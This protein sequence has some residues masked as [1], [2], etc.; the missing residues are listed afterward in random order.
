MNI[1]PMQIK[2]LKSSAKIMRHSA[3]DYQTQLVSTLR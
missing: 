2:G 3:P 1:T